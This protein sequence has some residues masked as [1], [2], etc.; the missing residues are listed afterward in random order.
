MGI[1][2]LHRKTQT[3]SLDSPAG[4]PPVRFLVGMHYGTAVC[5][6]PWP[7]ILLPE[8]NGTPKRCLERYI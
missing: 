3:Y 6:A 5:Y 8:A 2:F 7:D 4:E 1:F